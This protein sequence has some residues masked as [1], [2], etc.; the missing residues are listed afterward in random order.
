MS[1]IKINFCIDNSDSDS[2]ESGWDIEGGLSI[3]INGLILTKRMDDPNDDGFRGDFVFFN[4]KGWLHSVPKLCFGERCEV[5]LID[6]QEIFLFAPKDDFTYFKYFI[7]GMGSVFD[8][9]TG[10]SIRIEEI[11]KRYPNHEDGTPIKTEELVLEII[12]LSELFIESLGPKIEDKS[13]V[14]S[15]KQA[16]DDAWEAYESYVKR[17]TQN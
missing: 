13:D 4:L 15:F 1:D 2:F 9:G 17:S 5:E 10:K 11:N 14:I 12:R 8:V 3:T 7:G 16:L 6:S